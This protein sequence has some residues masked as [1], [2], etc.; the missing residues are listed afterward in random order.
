MPQHN[1][2]Q[3]IGILLVS[4]VCFTSA[5]EKKCYFYVILYINDDDD[6]DYIYTVL[7]EHN[8]NKV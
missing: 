8:L 4:E 6:D 2:I 7:L 5:N 3:L 1:I